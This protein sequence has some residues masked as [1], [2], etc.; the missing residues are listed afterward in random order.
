M[1]LCHYLMLESVA[2][3]TFCQ[4]KDFYPFPLNIFLKQKSSLCTA[5]FPC[6]KSL[7]FNVLIKMVRY[8]ANSDFSCSVYRKPRELKIG[9]TLLLSGE[10][11]S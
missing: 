7:L 2:M 1:L 4:K 6:F 5:Q 11:F 3:A 8:I 9:T 10:N